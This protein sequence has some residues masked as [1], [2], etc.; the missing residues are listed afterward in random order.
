MAVAGLFGEQQG[1]EQVKCVVSSMH[2][3]CPLPNRPFRGQALSDCARCSVSLTGSRFSSESA[4]RPF[5]HGIEGPSD[6]RTLARNVGASCWKVTRNMS[7]TTRA[8]SDIRL[9]SNP[10]WPMPAARLSVHGVNRGMGRV[11]G[12]IHASQELEDHR[13]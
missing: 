5:H 7:R 8:S 1:T 4:P 9:P 6:M 11:D 2:Q 10:R 12:P 13:G 3:A